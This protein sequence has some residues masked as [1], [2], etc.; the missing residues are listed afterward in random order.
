MQC[1]IK[2]L[3]ALVHAEKWGPLSCPNFE[4]PNNWCSVDHLKILQQVLLKVIWEERV[5]P[6]WIKRV[7]NYW[8]R[9]ALACCRHAKR[10]EPR[11]IRLDSGRR[12]HPYA[13]VCS[14]MRPLQYDCLAI[15]IRSRAYYHVASVLL[16]ICT[17]ISLQPPIQSWTWLYHEKA[18]PSQNSTIHSA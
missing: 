9:T 2:T 15:A 18:N 12:M 13:A 1:R 3:E 11:E 8:D 14:A 7:T 17:W 10:V 5:A 6:R 4:I 16:R